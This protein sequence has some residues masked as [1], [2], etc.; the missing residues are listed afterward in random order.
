M[1][2]CKCTLQPRVIIFQWCT[3][4]GQRVLRS[5][6][7]KAGCS[8]REQLSHLNSASIATSAN[9]CH[10]DRRD[11]DRCYRAPRAHTGARLPA[12]PWHA[13]SMLTCAPKH[14]SLLHS[15]SIAHWMSP[16]MEIVR[17]SFPSPGQACCC[18]CPV[19]CRSCCCVP[20]QTCLPSSPTWQ[21][22]TLLDCAVL[23]TRLHAWECWAAL[24]PDQARQASQWL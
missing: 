23:S 3:A 14:S 15:A 12:A 22:S 16:T 24:H 13:L 20:R 6:M 19:Q 10:A 9:F 21:H 8:C 17:C 11:A 1:S 2:V 7:R 5:L 18:C 4:Y